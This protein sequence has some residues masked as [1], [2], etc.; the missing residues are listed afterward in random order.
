MQKLIFITLFEFLSVSVSAQLFS[1]VKST[2]LTQYDIDNYQIV[3]SQKKGP[4]GP[5]YF[6][7]DVYK[8]RKYLSYAAYVLTKDSCKLMFKERSNYYI[9]FDL[10]K[11]TKEVFT[12]TKAAFSLSEIDSVTIQPVARFREKIM[13]TPY[14]KHSYDFVLDT[15]WEKDWDSLKTKKI[16]GKPLKLF[17]RKYKK[18]KVN[19]FDKFK[20]S[21]HFKVKIYTQK[22]CTT[23]ITYNGVFELENGWIY[24]IRSRNFFEQFW[25][26]KE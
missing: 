20:G 24:D 4:A 26:K 15:L 1:L 10:C 17:L 8:N 25:V 3:Y 23:L 16:Q 14:R 7:Y 6:E 9:L 13:V 11:N 2:T 12:A 18:A 22:G 21:C 19:R 5:A